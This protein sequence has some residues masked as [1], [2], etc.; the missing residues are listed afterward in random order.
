MWLLESF[1]GVWLKGHFI[2]CVISPPC[3]LPTLA[4]IFLFEFHLGFWNLL[5]SN[6]LACL[7]AP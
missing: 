6:S 5:G 7:E 2:F 3:D 4:S 1:L